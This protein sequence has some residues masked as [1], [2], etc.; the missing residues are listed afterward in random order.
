MTPLD[1]DG[2]RKLVAPTQPVIEE[3]GDGE[4]WLYRGQT[5]IEGDEAWDE[6]HEDLQEYAA[7]T[8]TALPALLERVEALERALEEAT[9]E[10]HAERMS[11]PD[12]GDVASGAYECARLDLL[13]GVREVFTDEGELAAR[14]EWI[15]D[16]GDASVGLAGS[17]AWYLAEDQTGAAIAALI[18]GNHD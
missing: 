18:G 6:Y 8:R 1:L 17:A 12:L 3:Y 13:S 5:Y 11:R 14:I 4:V 16:E 2:L 7:A 10:I 15:E 9:E